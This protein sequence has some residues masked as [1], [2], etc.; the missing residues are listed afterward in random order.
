[1]FRP[2][3]KIPMRGKLAIEGAGI[4]GRGAGEP[5]RGAVETIE[6]YIIQDFRRSERD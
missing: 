6:L 1:L 2:A 5:L 3:E 4:V